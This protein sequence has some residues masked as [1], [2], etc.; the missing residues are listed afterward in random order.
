LRNDERYII[1]AALSY[2]DSGA[3]NDDAPSMILQCIHRQKQH[4][5]FYCGKPVHQDK[6]GKE[7][8]VA[9]V[10]YVMMVIRKPEKNAKNKRI[11]QEHG[12]GVCVGGGLAWGLVR[13]AEKRK[14]LNIMM[15]ESRKGTDFSELNE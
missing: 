12:N 2:A 11:R 4:V 8:W 1:G 5:A 3:E 15:V 9:Q 14:E 7:S 6:K 10:G 13:S